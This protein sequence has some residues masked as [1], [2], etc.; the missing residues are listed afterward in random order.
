MFSHTFTAY[1]YCHWP[2]MPLYFFFK[3][4]RCEVWM[5]LWSDLAD[6]LFEEVKE[7]LRLLR[8]LHAWYLAPS[9][10]QGCMRVKHN[11]SNYKDKS[12]LLL[13]T[14]VTLL[15]ERIGGKKCWMNHIGRKLEERKNWVTSKTEIR[16]KDF[17][18]TRQSMQKYT[19][20]HSRFWKGELW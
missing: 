10:L 2:F 12:N 14:Y 5:L 8:I 6:L 13:I 1:A 11:L 17:P 19:P 7:Q 9:R 15:Q 16:K 4:L 20:I 3:L 18:S